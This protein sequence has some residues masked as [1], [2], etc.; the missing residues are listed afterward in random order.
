MEQAI[1][2]G[3]D[4]SKERLDVAILPSQT[5]FAV[6]RDAGGLAELVQRLRDLVPERVVLEATGG[7]EQVVAASLGG[8]GLPVI[9][10]NPR[11]IRDFARAIGRLAKTDRIDAE[12]IA[13]F[14]ERVRPPVRPL[15][16]EQG[17]LLDELVT[18][19]RQVIEMKTAE[20]NRARQSRTNRLK[21]RIERHCA[22][23][24]KE[25]SEIEAEL[26]DTIR[27]TPIWRETDDLLQSVPGVGPVLARTLIAELPEIGC[28][29][30]RSIAALVGL[31]PF[32]RDSGAWRGK[33]SI[34]GGRSSVR[35][36]LYM[37]TVSAIRCN[38]VIKAFYAR[39]RAAGKPAKLAITACMRKLITILNAIVR[40]RQP[41]QTA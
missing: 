26:N 35:N 38:P 13:L 9:V 36:V 31:A 16:D 19:R 32:N 17:R 4:V 39:L 20:G 21:K 3:F 7:F 22:L 10:I 37:A 34:Q 24:Q 8:A 5:S 25:L 40:D 15:P 1:S 18:R 12:V 41:W 30:R 2:I 23:L 14:G 6:G 29:D 27:G 28:I 33:R 11:Q